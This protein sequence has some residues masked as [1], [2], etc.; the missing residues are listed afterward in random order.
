MPFAFACREHHDDPFGLQASSH[1]EQCIDGGAVQPLGVI[2]QAEQRPLLCHLGKQGKGWPPRSGTGWDPRAGRCQTE[3]SPQ[4]G[5]L[6]WRQ[7]LDPLAKRPKQLM[8]SG[9]RELGLG[10]G[11]QGRLADA[12]LARQN[13]RAALLPVSRCEQ[14]LDRRQLGRATVQYARQVI[15]DVARSSTPPT[16]GRSGCRHPAPRV[17]SIA[18]RM[19]TSWVTSEVGSSR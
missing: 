7:P 5:D 8:Q 1:K 4:R 9:K 19:Q 10:L 12:G 15:A 17:H 18:Q 14:E 11:Q 2:D 13:Q 3:R 6:S 16:G